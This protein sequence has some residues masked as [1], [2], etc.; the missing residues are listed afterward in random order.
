MPK[1]VLNPFFQEE[2]EVHEFVSSRPNLER[3]S[4]ANP[5]RR[6]SLGG[7]YAG[8][9]RTSSVFTGKERLFNICPE[10]AFW[11]KNCCGVG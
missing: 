8:G 2:P 9:R 10:S 11:C 5:V 6:A 1:L 7:A 4:S 3:R